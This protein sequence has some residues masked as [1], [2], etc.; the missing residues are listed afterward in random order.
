M[1]CQLLLAR[2]H[3]VHVIRQLSGVRGG[4]DNDGRRPVV[5]RASNDGRMGGNAFITLKFWRRDV[6]VHS[7]WVVHGRDGVPSGLRDAIPDCVGHHGF[8]MDNV[9]HR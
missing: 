2:R 8:D 6:L 9:P 4:H 5:V 3:D 1:P 7:C